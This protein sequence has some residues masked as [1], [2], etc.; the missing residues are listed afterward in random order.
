MKVSGGRSG[1]LDKKPS[2]LVIKTNL[3][4]SFDNRWAEVKIEGKNISSRSNHICTIFG[5]DLFVH[6]G[7][8]VERGILGDFHSMDIS[9]G[10]QEFVWKKHNN[11]C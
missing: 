5:N 1:A 4:N 8:D 2:N 10:C 7:Y 6:G 9:E 3:Q 11:L